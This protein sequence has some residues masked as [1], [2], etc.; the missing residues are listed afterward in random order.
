LTQRS[1]WTKTPDRMPKVHF[2]QENVTV[3]AAAGSLISEVAAAN[4]I[5]VCRQ[6]FGWT[7]VGGYSV[8]VQGEPGSLSPPTLW[9]RLLRVKGWRRHANRARVLRDVRIWTQQGLGGR[10]GG[11]RKI[12]PPA[13]PTEDAEA[14]RHPDN[15]AGTAA[16]PYG[17][18]SALEAGK[19]AG[20]EADAAP[21]PE[22]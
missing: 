11:T 16:N 15:E 10:L 2:V 19:H 21:T 8:W 3:E 20:A 13:R 1:G 22:A 4:G 6:T 18:P 17:H 7:S 12:D 14:E 9:E 5:A